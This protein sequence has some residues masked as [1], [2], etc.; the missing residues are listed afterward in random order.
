M[1]R[2]I[3]EMKDVQLLMIAFASSAHVCTLSPTFPTSS[4]FTPKALATTYPAPAFSSQSG[5]HH[6]RA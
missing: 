2:V 6:N 3:R 1:V 5:Q 4:S